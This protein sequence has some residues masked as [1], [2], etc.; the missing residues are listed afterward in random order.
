[1]IDRQYLEVP[2][3][4]APGIPPS[5]F[6]E[7]DLS[8]NKSKTKICMKKQ[9]NKELNNLNFIDKLVETSNRA[10]AARE[11][12]KLHNIKSTFRSNSS[13]VD[14]SRIFDTDH[15][16][17]VTS[18]TKEGTQPKVNKIRS[19]ININIP[20]NRSPGSSKKGKRSK[21]STVKMSSY[22]RSFRRPAN[23]TSS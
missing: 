9:R 1:M 23:S 3:L 16:Y 14:Q 17:N 20:R 19:T 22:E 10:S 6:T 13:F 2:V 15:I 8:L 18:I 7:L 4:F 21:F 12:A 11:Q 5:V